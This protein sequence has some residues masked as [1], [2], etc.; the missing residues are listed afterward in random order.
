MN[1]WNISE[2]GH[3]VQVIAPVDGN[4][5][6]PVTAARF[7]MAKW[8]HA[9]IIVGFGVTGGTPTSILLSA[10]TAQSSGTETALAFRAYSQTTA[11]G[12]VLSTGT[13][14]AATGI[15]TIS[16]NNGIFYTIE[17][18]SSQLPSDSPWV[19]LNVTIPNS[20]NLLCAFAILSGG[21]QQS[22]ASATVLT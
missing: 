14:Y 4:N 13:D 3:I 6:A 9:S 16:G 22:P 2:A 10:Y 5:G 8:A 7:S 1:G 19:Q 17:L 21:R 20:S 18:D 11:A 15:T 12:D